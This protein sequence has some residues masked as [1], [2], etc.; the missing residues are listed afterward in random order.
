MHQ[1]AVHQSGAYTAHSFYSVT[2]WKRLFSKV[3]KNLRFYQKT[4]HLNLPVKKPVITLLFSHRFSNQIIYS[5]VYRGGQNHFG[6]TFIAF[7]TFLEALLLMF[8]FVLRFTDFK[9]PCDD[10]CFVLFDEYLSPR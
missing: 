1:P 10:T 9:Q 7:Q 2:C 6:P 4:C 3:W 5:V 8:F